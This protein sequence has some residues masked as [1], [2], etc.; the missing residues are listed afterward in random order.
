MQST[1]RGSTLVLGSLDI[2]NLI[3]IP[4]AYSVSYF[5]LGRLGT[6]FGGLSPP[7]PPVATGLR[8]TFTG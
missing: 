6:L 8:V 1:A 3:K 4:V 2:E 5:H 7:K